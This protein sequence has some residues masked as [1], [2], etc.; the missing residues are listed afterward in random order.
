MP[1]AP[2]RGQRR[3]RQ[4]L[5][6][7]GGAGA[8]AAAR[9]KTAADVVP[10]LQ[11]RAAAGT[12]DAPHAPH[13][14]GIHSTV[15]DHLKRHADNGA[16]NRLTARQRKLLESLS[17]P[18]NPE[19]GEEGGGRV[20]PFRV[21]RAL[22]K[23]EAELVDTVALAALQRRAV[24]SDDLTASS[25]FVLTDGLSAAARL[26]KGLEERYGIAVLVLSEERA[27]RHPTFPLTPKRG[28]SRSPP[29]AG[30]PTALPQRTA[31][32]GTKKK[33]T[34]ASPPKD[35]VD[36]PHSCAAAA[37][38]VVATPE[39]FLAVD[40][41]SAMWKFIGAYVVA[42]MAPAAA[43]AEKSHSLVR[44]MS[45]EGEGGDSPTNASA[46]LPLAVRLSQH[47]W[48]C[49]G[50]T[51]VGAVLSLDKGVLAAPVLDWLLTLRP[52]EAVAEASA[53]SPAAVAQPP[54]QRRPVSVH[55][56]VAE[57][58]HRFGFLFSLV[59]G[60]SSGRGLVVHL[61]TKEACAFLYN[62]L[63]HFLDDIP[64]HVRLLT[65]YEGESQFS[66]SVASIEDR[67]RLC[68]TF[69]DIVTSASEKAGHT[70]AVL[71]SCYGLVPRRGHIFLAYDIVPDIVNFNGFVADALT[72][73][74][75]GTEEG[76]GD[77]GD[78]GDHGRTG[79][80]PPSSSSSSS[81]AQ[82]DVT[83]R[84]R[85]RGVSP[86]PRARKAGKTTEKAAA[87][88]SRDAEDEQTTAVAMYHHILLLLRP[89]EVRGALRHLQP[90]PKGQ[91]RFRVTY[92]PLPQ[93]PSLSSYLLYGEA[94]RNLC[95][96]VFALANTAYHA[97]RA[98][99]IAYCTVGPRDVYRET[100]VNLERVSEEFG[101]TQLPL[102]DLRLKDTVFR[103]KEDLYKAAK[104][105]QLAER[106]AY[107]RFADAN[108]IGDVPEE[109]TVDE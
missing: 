7:D 23:H 99:M 65:D 32:K 82:R 95:R 100:E 71:L 55:Y 33:Q 101:L 1:S 57:G 38:V 9:T 42:L 48:D 52:M 84:K 15:I 66:A 77:G 19:E 73:G 86:P 35:V 20:A 92:A 3:L 13:D 26:R 29:P 85:G 28:R 88:A 105:K 18:I 69:N 8:K 46:R 96:T 97:Y 6:G 27:E 109:H 14:S 21:K 72:P 2:T 24:S 5:E 107:K 30:L 58:I 89:N 60:L 83:V 94:L 70:S 59:R 78:E 68:Q 54:P 36:E 80:E 50:H 49:L 75:Y 106:R 98:T 76:S 90:Q 74:A 79:G 17:G 62:A 16:T 91:D 56:A 4:F 102:L 103:P 47:R 39:G 22:M 63:Y 37:A 12:K 51:T 104:V 11:E 53:L 44:L 31:R 93:K 25:L 40:K 45:T 61:A 43:A 34:S 10:V 87:S 67:Y 108:I 81:L 64:G 41:R